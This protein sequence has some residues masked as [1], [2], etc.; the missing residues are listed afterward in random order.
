MADKK[1][2]A[3][4]P[5]KITRIY[6]TRFVHD[7]THLPVTMQQFQDLTNEILVE[8]NKLTAP[9]ALEADYFA[10]VL[11]SALHST[12]GDVGFISKYALYEACIHRVS[13]H[14]TYDAVQAIQ[15]RL[16]AE[17]KPEDLKEIQAEP[18][19]DETHVVPAQSAPVTESSVH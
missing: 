3:Q 10:Q 12:K 7:R 14:L 13:S 6:D 19:S 5:A 17:K 9:H 1:L 15:A 2:A 8:I 4:K 16:K 11:M 18:N